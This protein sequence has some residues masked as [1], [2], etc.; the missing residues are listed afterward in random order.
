MDLICDVCKSYIKKIALIRFHL[1]GRKTRYCS[2]CLDD[3][4]RKDKERVEVAKEPTQKKSEKNH[5]K[6]EVSKQNREQ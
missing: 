4:V 6:N 2:K 1:T 3:V 5:P